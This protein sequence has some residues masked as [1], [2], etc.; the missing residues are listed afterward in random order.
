LHSKPHGCSASEASAAGSFTTIPVVASG[1]SPVSA[2]SIL[3][4]DE[5][6]RTWLVGQAG[7]TLQ[8]FFLSS[9]TRRVTQ[10]VSVITYGRFSRRS[11]PFL[12]LRLN[13]YCK[14]WPMGT[15]PTCI[16]EVPSLYLDWIK[17]YT[18][19]SSFTPTFWKILKY[20]LPSLDHLLQNP[21]PVSCLWSSGYFI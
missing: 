11:F 21:Y 17:R 9:N 5:R 18:D 16:C 15:D 14:E 10:P 2:P 6:I 12:Q 4:K 1:K 13:S 3:N 8:L 19:Q 7:M 20:C